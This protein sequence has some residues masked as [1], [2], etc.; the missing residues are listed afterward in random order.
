M[1]HTAG[2]DA[3]VVAGLGGFVWWARRERGEWPWLVAVLLQL[4][5]VVRVGG[6]FMQGRF[7]AG[8]FLV[9]AA[10]AI[11]ARGADLVRRRALWSG[12]ILYVG[13]FPWTPVNKPVHGGSSLIRLGIADERAVYAD[14]LSVWRWAAARRAQRP[15]PDLVWRE[16]G[17]A[18]R[19]GPGLPVVAPNIGVLG[20]AAGP[21]PII[22]DPLALSDP[23]LARLPCDP[24]WRI[25][26]FPRPVPPSYLASL[27]AGAPVVLDDPDR[28][29]LARDIALITRGD[30][31]FATARWRAILRRN[32]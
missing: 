14:A 19:G 9:A 26:H 24:A 2:W 10:V 12:L 3:L 32:R 22:I 17:E 27:A 31:L 15:F 8:I 6:D 7:L 23:F 18:L 4:A 20:W 25:G 13:L 11:A 1:L 29:A 5:Y 28:Q 30:D 16:E 21:D